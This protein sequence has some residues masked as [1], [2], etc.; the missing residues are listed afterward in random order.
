MHL[1]K[2]IVTINNETPIRQGKRILALPEEL[3]SREARKL[4]LSG[5]KRLLGA[6]YQDELIGFIRMTYADRVANIVQ[7]LSHDEALRQE[8][9]QC[10]DRKGG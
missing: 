1:C 6:Y 5:K 9:S 3:R 4:D 2:G 7:I 10:P 8:A